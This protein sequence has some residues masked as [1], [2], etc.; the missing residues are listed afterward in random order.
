MAD[1]RK[2]YGTVRYHGK[3]REPGGFWEANIGKTAKILGLG[4]HEH[5]D[6]ILIV[7]PD[8]SCSHPEM[9]KYVNN[10]CASFMCNL[11]PIDEE[12]KGFFVAVMFGAE[13]PIKKRYDL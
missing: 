4:P 11:E 1:G 8:E 6:Q 9:H 5:P 13:V 7:E 2:Y 12:A 10:G 3:A